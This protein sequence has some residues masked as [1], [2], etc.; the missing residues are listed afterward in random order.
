MT[1]YTFDHLSWDPMSKQWFVH[2]QIPTNLVFTESTMIDSRSVVQDLC[3]LLESAKDQDPNKGTN[4]GIV[5]GQHQ[6]DKNGKLF[7]V[8]SWNI[9]QQSSIGDE[10]AGRIGVPLAGEAVRWATQYDFDKFC[11]DNPDARYSYDWNAEVYKAFISPA[12]VT[13]KV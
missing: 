3:L 10:P 5:T 1:P 12:R 9:R 6:I 8:K 7:I 13:M 4:Y 2:L 11:F